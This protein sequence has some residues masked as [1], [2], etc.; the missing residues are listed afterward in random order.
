M[1]SN[2]QFSSA[3]IPLFFVIFI[4][5]LGFGIMFPIFTPMFIDNSIGLFSAQSSIQLRNFWFEFSIASYCL[6]MFLTS[7]VLGSLSDRFG[8]KKILIF[9][10]SG[11]AAGLLLSAVGVLLHNLFLILFGRIIAGA[12]AGSY[13]IAQAAMV[14]IS[15]PEQK[16]SR[17]GL[18]AIANGIGFACG[19]VVGGLLLDP[20]IW[21]TTNYLL[22][23]WVNAGLAIL[24][25]LTIMLFFKETFKGNPHQKINLFTSLQNIRDAFVLENTRWLCIELLLFMIGY[26]TF[27]TMMPVFITLYFHKTGAWIGYFMTYFA[28][29]FSSSLLILL[30]KIT[31][32]MSLHKMVGISLILQII[33]CSLFVITRTEFLL[34]FVTIPIAIGVPLAFVGLFTLLSNTADTNNQ[35]KI[36]GV[37]GSLA[38]LSWGIGPLIAGFV[39]GIHFTFAYTISILLLLLALMVSFFSGKQTAP[40]VSIV[41]K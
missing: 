37:G 31:N 1:S 13:P 18:V 2:K 7:P 23:F 26:A 16:A 30:P 39:G 28:I 15:A 9:S 35:G 6:C 3:I 24:C 25:I 8:R 14:D 34:W 38:A 4:D 17:I 33:F 10:L 27:F 36:M 29:L 11:L 20:R 41:Q 32:R 22:P 21:P 5:A 40:R 19:P 12:T